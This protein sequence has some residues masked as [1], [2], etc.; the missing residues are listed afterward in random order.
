MF[1]VKLVSV[2]K[3]TYFAAFTVCYLRLAERLRAVTGSLGAGFDQNGVASAIGRTAILV[4]RSIGIVR[5]IAPQVLQPDQDDRNSTRCLNGCITEVTLHKLSFRRER[6]WNHH[7]TR[8]LSSSAPVLA[9][10]PRS[11]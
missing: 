1:L 9:S 3:R 5:M 6:K 11:P 10:A 8:P 2:H 4:G 7:A